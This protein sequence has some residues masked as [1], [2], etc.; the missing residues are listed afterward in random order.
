MT[1]PTT[2]NESSQGLFQKP[3]TQ[4]TLPLNQLA[5]PKMNANFIDDLLVSGEKK[6]EKKPRA[7]RATQKKTEVATDAAAS[8]AASAAPAP[9][10]PLATATGDI[11]AANAGNLTHNIALALR[12]LKDDRTNVGALHYIDYILKLLTQVREHYDGFDAGWVDLEAWVS[13]FEELRDS[14][15]KRK[16]MSCVDVTVQMGTLLRCNAQDAE[17]LL[18]Q[19]KLIRESLRKLSDYEEQIEQL[20]T[21]NE[22]KEVIIRVH[23]DETRRL[24]D[25]NHELVQELKALRE[26]DAASRVPRMRNVGQHQAI[27]QTQRLPSANQRRCEDDEVLMQAT[28]A[29]TASSQQT[30][31]V[32]PDARIVRR[33]VLSTPRSSVPDMEPEYVPDH[34]R[35]E[36]EI[37]NVEQRAY[38]RRERGTADNP[39]EIDSQDSDEFALRM[40][41]NSAAAAAKP[42]KPRAKKT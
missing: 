30:A 23:E 35:A 1:K 25:E 19:E 40:P 15:Q 41:R 3:N 42:R 9:T 29:N 10:A 34:R 8:S 2:Q 16:V 38:L 11:D 12:H 27:T 5:D 7:K 31:N 33:R 28:P 32:L 22:A 17:L 6:P 18:S 39:F 26:R 24:K 36:R 21:S 20:N 37:G 4:G 14:I 13:Y